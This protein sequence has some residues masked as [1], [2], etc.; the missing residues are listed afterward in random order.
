MTSI[1]DDVLVLLQCPITTKRLVKAKP[2][3]LR[4]VNDLI[5]R[6]EL[7]NR[8]GETVDDRLD[9]GLVDETGEWLYTIRDG[10][11]CLLA[12]EAISQDQIDIEEDESS[13]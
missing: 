2:E 12:D 4:R 7:T 11:V 3:L 10:I 8:I 5:H 13:I 1:T 9:E 6:G